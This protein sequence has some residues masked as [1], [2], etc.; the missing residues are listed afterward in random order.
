MALLVCKLAVCRRSECPGNFHIILELCGSHV[1]S[2]ARSP[3]RTL[4]TFEALLQF[5][6]YRVARLLC[7]LVK[8]LTVL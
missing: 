4:L 2:A 5:A 1:T 7:V 6:E 3:G 8:A